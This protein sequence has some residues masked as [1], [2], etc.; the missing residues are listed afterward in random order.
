M[1]EISQNTKGEP[2]NSFM[3]AVS[4]SYKQILNYLGTSIYNFTWSQYSDV[5][6]I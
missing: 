3:K 5:N 2:W 4:T 1:A 6:V